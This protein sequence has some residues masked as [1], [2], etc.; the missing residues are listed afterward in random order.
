MACDAIV[1]QS[2]MTSVGQHGATGLGA[3]QQ[4]AGRWRLVVCAVSVALL[5]MAVAVQGHTQDRG[6]TIFFSTA[7]GLGEAWPDDVQFDRG[8][9]LGVAWEVLVGWGL[10]EYLAV[11]IDFGT[12]QTSLLG[13]PFHFHNGFTP[14]LEWTPFGG[15]G[16]FFGVGSG[17]G[18]T[19]GVVPPNRTRHGIAVNPRA[20]FRW[21]LP[22]GAAVATVVGAWVHHYPGQ[23]TAV[24]ALSVL[25]IRMYG[26]TRD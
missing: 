26:S 18:T 24:V 4:T 6:D 15:D 16:L 1:D 10:T 9:T 8:P 13:L 20:G 12:W 25:E 23:G 17:L 3:C 19:D 14:R 22:G 5:I 11:G 2:G 7:V 21:A